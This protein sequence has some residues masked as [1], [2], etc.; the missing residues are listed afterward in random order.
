MIF[1]LLTHPSNISTFQHFNISWAVPTFQH[2]N[3]LTFH[4]QFQHFNISTFYEHIR[5]TPH[6]FHISTFQHFNISQ[7]LPHIS[8]PAPPPPRPQVCDSSHPTQHIE[9]TASAAIDLWYVFS[10]GLG[11]VLFER[12]RVCVFERFRVCFVR[13]V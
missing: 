1:S 3:I 11:F 13:A 9:W 8:R 10:S 2:F 6:R 4:G 12:F 5:Q 7:Q